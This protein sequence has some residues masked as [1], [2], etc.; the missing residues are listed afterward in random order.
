MTKKETERHIGFKGEIP[1]YSYKVWVGKKQTKM[2]M[3]FD[4][5]HI[6]D[7]LG[8]IKPTMIKRIKEKK[9]IDLEPEPLGPR[10]AVVGRP[11]EY[12]PAFK[13]LKAWVDSIGGPPESVRKKI[14][15]HWV[16][17]RKVARKANKN[18]K[19]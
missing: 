10:G 13:I 12:Q 4:E 16:D 5:Q 9:E 18:G 7:Q 1:P 15:E 2:M 8:P 19:K 14:R 11:A 6:R 3:G 17:Y